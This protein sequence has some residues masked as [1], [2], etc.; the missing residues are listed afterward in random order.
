MPVTATRLAHVGAGD[1][2]PLVL[3]RGGEHLLEQLAVAGLQLGSLPQPQLGLAD[4]RRQG[5]ADSLQV[6]KTE[7]P[8]LAGD[9]GDA[10]VKLS[11]WEG[12]RDQRAEL[13]FEAAD[14]AAQLRPG[15]PLVA[16]YAKRLGSL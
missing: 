11:A 16:A 7:G 12:V 3:R 10:S 14:L 9:S 5:V 8:R 1:P 15:E 13:C 6:A 2:H 4:S